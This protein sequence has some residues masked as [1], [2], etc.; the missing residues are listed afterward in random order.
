MLLLIIYVFVALFFSFLCSVSEAVILSVSQSY[1][2]VL[3][4]KQKHSGI[5]LRGLNN[6][7]N[8]T[9]SAILTLN[10]I[11]H[12]VGAAGAGAQAAIVF[13]DGYLGVASAVLTLLILIFSEV[14]PKTIG[15]S[16]WR[17]LAPATAYFVHYL[18]IALYPIVY[19]LEKMTSKFTNQDELSGLSRTELKAL[20]EL[21]HQHGQLALH[22]LN[23]MQNLMSLH[24][25]RVKSAMTPRTVVFS[26]DENMTVESF[27]HQHSKQSF[28]RIP[29]YEQGDTEKICGFVLKSDLLVAQARGNG[30][31]SVRAYLKEMVTV[32]SSMPL[33]RTLEHFFPGR[34]HMI[35]VVDEYGGLEGILTME[36]LLET[37]L[38]LEII[39]E[40][41]K[42]VSMQK[43]AL[44]KWKQRLRNVQQSD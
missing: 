32:S 38:G 18:C 35:L 16:Y 14:I 40:K 31:K 36:D 22:E 6:N 15:A 27:Y 10:T 13:G 7:I 25:T 41:D 29:V 21:S 5:L 2:A 17:A 37:L 26:I 4:G 44:A 30:D 43:V 9:L 39:D 1:I 34:N 8:K 33:S 19:V 11:A 20:A 28:S 42:N 12:T 3:E 24:Q 23:I